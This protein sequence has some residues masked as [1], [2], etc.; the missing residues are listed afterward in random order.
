M[1][2]SHFIIIEDT[3]IKASYQTFSLRSSSNYFITNLLALLALL[4]GSKCMGS[5]VVACIVPCDVFYQ[6]KVK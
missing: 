2:Y 4:E 5:A 3:K 1:L 6:C